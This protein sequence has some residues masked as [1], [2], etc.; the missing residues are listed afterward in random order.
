VPILHPRVALLDRE[1][2][3][4]VV[5]PSPK[6]FVARYV[7]PPGVDP[8]AELAL[9][10]GE[11]FVPYPLGRPVR[12][13]SVKG[14]ELLMRKWPEPGKPV[15]KPEPIATIKTT[16][17]LVAELSQPP[18]C[19]TQAAAYF[20]ITQPPSKQNPAKD[21]LFVALADR[22]ALTPLPA[23]VAKET[24][25]GCGDTKFVAEAPNQ[26]KQSIDILLCDLE[27][28]CETP[29]RPVFKPWLEKHSRD[30]LAVPTATG[31]AAVMSAQ[32]GEK[33]GLYYAQSTDGG[34]FYERAR[35]VGEGT[36]ARGRVDFEALVSLG[37]RTL[38][39]VSA[40][41]TGTSRRGLYVI[42]SDDDGATWNPP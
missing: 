5:E 33:W 9:P 26:D 42:V 6:K 31:A 8:P 23:A 10:K 27:G 24:R 37:K 4:F 21:Y 20:K 7:A 16:P 36:G 18:A 38:L 41:V 25:I 28:K 2:A 35:V 12:L 3:S 1:T 39:L 32:A 17:S 14:R 29:T 22:F 30:I 40:D 15:D 34:K 13:A 11:A 19:E